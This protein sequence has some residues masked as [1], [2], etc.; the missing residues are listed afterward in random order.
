MK[1]F[2]NEYWTSYFLAL[3]AF[4]YLTTIAFFLAFTLE[5]LTCEGDWI[6]AV[7]L[8]SLTSIVPLIS[9]SSMYSFKN[10][11]NANLIPKVA[12]ACFFWYS[13][14]S[15]GIL[16]SADTVTYPSSAVFWLSSAINGLKSFVL[17]RTLLPPIVAL[18]FESLRAAPSLSLL[19][20][21]LKW[22]CFT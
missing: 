19:S 9:L 14:L 2:F 6:P 18:T 12:W 15:D 16:T 8:K 7:T 20:N 21:A 10:A 3:L 13:D 17:E 1:F 4:L 11:P 22:I 5:I